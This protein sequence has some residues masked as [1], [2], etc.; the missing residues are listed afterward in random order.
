MIRGHK[1]ARHAAR[2]MERFQAPATGSAS[3]IHIR[4]QGSLPSPTIFIRTQSRENS[5]V[6]S[7]KNSIRRR[8]GAALVV[9]SWFS[10]GDRS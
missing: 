10:I 1:Y 7:R 6:T 9:A 5:R 3:V 2:T 4:G 8:R